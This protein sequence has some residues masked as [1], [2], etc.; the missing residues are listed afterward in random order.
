MKE[1][2]ALITG[3]FMDAYHTI[4]NFIGVSNDWLASVLPTPILNF[5]DWVGERSSLEWRG[6]SLIVVVGL[7]VISIAFGEIRERL[8]DLFRKG[9]R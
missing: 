5:F 7:V 8:G 2:L 4:G 1:L 6:I 3:L 9:R